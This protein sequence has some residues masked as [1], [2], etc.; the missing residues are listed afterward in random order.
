M[1][2]RTFKRGAPSFL[3][4]LGALIALVWLADFFFYRERVGATLGMFVI[5]LTAAVVAT[6]WQR[7]KGRASM[8]GI[9]GAF[10]MGLALIDD[11]NLLALA[12]A[13]GALGFAVLASR[14]TMLPNAWGWVIRLITQLLTAFERPVHDLGLV[15]RVR[16]RGG[17]AGIMGRLRLLILPVLGSAVFL[18][19]FA[20]ANPLIDDALSS[21]DANM[22]IGGVSPLRTAF[23]IVIALVVWIF[24]RP[25][26][27]SFGAHDAGLDRP[28]PAVAPAA[29]ILLSLIAFNVVFA[30]QNGLDIMFLWSGAPLPDG[31][32]LAEYAHRGAYPLIAT[33]LLAGLF[34]LV[35][36]HPQSPLA[37]DR[38]A[39]WL[40]YLWIAQN[41]FLVASSIERTLDYIDV[42]SLTRLRIAALLWMGLVAIGL[43]LICWR[44]AA[45]KSANWLINA[46]AFAALAVLSF[47]SVVDLGRMA[48][49]WNVRH[50]SDV[51]GTGTALDVCYLERLGPSAL[52]P[53]IELERREI[54]PDL[55]QQIELS[56]ATIYYQAREN[57]HDWR[58]WTW[59]NGRRLA[60]AE[61][62]MAAASLP[63][64]LNIKGNCPTEDEIYAD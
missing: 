28:L 22:L 26:V 5:A 43:M 1:T 25:S 12:L 24:L 41:I 32:T 17:H 19:L 15:R 11:P 55:R 30:L 56:R 59:R 48:A 58:G 37:D 52:L 4:K 54:A 29:S 49:A 62:Q 13:W 45:R 57:T 38:R 27:I 8:L 36:L 10:A 40:V 23:V 60:E 2:I 64:P 16:R 3:L 34:V 6:H 53:L 21:F 33:A 50:A 47:C 63:Q 14:S 31:M 20:M 46:N 61:H 18:A 42:Y 44:I 7:L 51:G 9:A 39:R 35:A